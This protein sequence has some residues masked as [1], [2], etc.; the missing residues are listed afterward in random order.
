MIAEIE[1]DQLAGG[2]EIV[3][4][5]Q[6]SVFSFQIA[7]FQRSLKTEPYNSA[8]KL[9]EFD[10]FNCVA[11]TSYFTLSDPPVLTLRAF[12]PRSLRAFLCI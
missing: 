2:N 5:F 3:F 8:I 4:S 7:R 9:V 11:G 1:P 10:P 12:V 6:F